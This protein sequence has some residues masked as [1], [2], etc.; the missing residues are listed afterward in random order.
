MAKIREFIR[1]DGTTNHDILAVAVDCQAAEETMPA[2]K[3]MIDKK[4]EEA[5]G[6][7]RAA[8]YHHAC[9]SRPLRRVLG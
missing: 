1:R 3:I 2:D 7:N 4:I 5:V 8:L 6:F 9:A